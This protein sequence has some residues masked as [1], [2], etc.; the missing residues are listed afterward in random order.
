MKSKLFTLLL[1]TL[2]LS[3]NTSA[4]DILHPTIPNGWMHVTLW[5]KTNGVCE[6]QDDGVRYVWG[7]SRAYDAIYIMV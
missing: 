5:E 2:T 6:S 1:F 4:Q 7:N 3:F